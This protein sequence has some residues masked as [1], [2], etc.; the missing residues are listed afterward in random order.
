LERLTLDD[1]P[2]GD[3]TEYGAIA[4][5]Y[6]KIMQGG[7]A[8]PVNT[9]SKILYKFTKT[10]CEEFNQKIFTK[11]DETKVMEQLYKLQDPKAVVT[12]HRYNTL[13]PIGL[14][15]WMQSQHSGLVKD[16]E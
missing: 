14:I 1:Y 3:V 9:G 8:L 7:Y 13:G 16:H 11:L 15:S 2:G 4:Q 10:S 12:D 6:I 5:K